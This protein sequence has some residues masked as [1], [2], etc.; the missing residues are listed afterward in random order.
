MA[1]KNISIRKELYDKLTRLKTKEQSYSDFIEKLLNEG[2][3]GS[4]SRM[5]KYF[6]SWENIPD[7]VFEEMKRLRERT[8]KSI[9]NRIIRRLEDLE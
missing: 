5:M 7:D 4:F 9:H 3:K 2:L 8:N 6:G 1:S